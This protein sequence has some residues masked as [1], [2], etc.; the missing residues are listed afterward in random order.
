MF[1][2]MLKAARERFNRELP[3]P[4]LLG[5]NFEEASQGTGSANLSATQQAR[6][7][8]SRLLAEDDNAIQL[9]VEDI[10]HSIRY[11]D[12]EAKP[13][14]ERRY[15]VT[16]TG[17]EELM[18]GGAKAGESLYMSAS[19]IE[20]GFEITLKTSAETLQEQ[21]ERRRQ[22]IEGLKM[23]AIT[24]AQFIQDWG[25]ADADH[26]M[27]ELRK[28]RLKKRNEGLKAAAQDEIV[29]ALFLTL[30]DIMVPPAA[31]GVPPS[32]PAAGAPPGEGM[33]QPTVRLPALDGPSGGASPVEAMV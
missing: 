13:E 3:N 20:S 9:I 23:G 8:L 7:P 24:S 16:A 2:E 4:F 5:S 27:R 18:R 19:M 1:L 12:Y 21:A 26:Q 17:G 22:A 10:L 25:Y 11:W 6:F 31:A 30:A 28:E 15:Y 33:P 14:E 29:K 32:P